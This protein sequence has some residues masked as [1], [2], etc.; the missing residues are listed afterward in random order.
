ME[1]V[2]NANGLA[3]QVGG[4]LQQYSGAKGSQLSTSVYSDFEQVAKAAPRSAMADGL[5]AAFRSARTPPF[6]Q[7][8]SHLFIQS[9]QQQQTGVINRLI[10]AAGP[11]VVY[12]ILSG[13]CAGIGAE[14]RQ[15]E[16]SRRTKSHPALSR[17]LL[18][19]QSSKIRRSLIKSATSMPKIR[20][21]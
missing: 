2:T 3:N 1:A 20:R 18:H 13:M 7:M 15:T 17:R 4:I 5:A 9:N 21:W 10:A 14:R 11:E 8:L 6:G 19:R 12:R 16:L